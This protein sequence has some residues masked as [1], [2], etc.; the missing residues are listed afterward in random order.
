MIADMV[1]IGGQDGSA[2]GTSCVIDDEYC[3]EIADFVSKQGD[4][5]EGMVQRYLTE[6]DFVQ[7]AAIQQGTTSIHLYEFINKARIMVG[8]INALSSE[9]KD[10]IS[11]FIEEVNEEDQ[12]VF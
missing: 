10:T 4:R 2:G 5:L 7:S 9:V 3:T 6:L 12:I 1:A 11:N 8:Q